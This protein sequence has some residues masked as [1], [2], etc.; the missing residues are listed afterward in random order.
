MDE[1]EQQLTDEYL[2]LL[3]KTGLD[4]KWPAIEFTPGHYGGEH[5]A[6]NQDGST[7]MI[8]SDRGQEYEVERYKDRYKLL[9]ALCS[10]ATWEVAKYDVQAPPN[11]HTHELQEMT[12]TRQV[13]L[14]GRIDPQWADECKHN[15]RKWCKVRDRMYA[16]DIKRDREGK[17]SV[18]LLYLF[19]AAVIAL[20]I[21]ITQFAG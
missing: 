18:V 17:I 21:Y 6:F 1:Q 13:E 7:S 10:G 12:H 3:A 19:C 20:A 4:A 8:R 15:W 14:L 11:T 5:V 16:Q 9:A 2:A